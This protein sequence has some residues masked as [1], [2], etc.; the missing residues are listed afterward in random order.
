VDTLRSI[1]IATP[2]GNFHLII[3][4]HDIVRASGFGTLEAL[5]MRLPESIRTAPLDEGD[6]NHPYAQLVRAYYTGDRSALDAIP[7]EQPGS[8]FQQRVWAA[9]SDVPYGATIS[10]KELATAADNPAAIRAA[11]TICGLNRLILLVPCHRVL[12][13]DGSIGSYLYGP[14]I[15]AALLRHESG[16]SA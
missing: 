10:Y 7:R 8:D 13:S 12:K 16:M 4:A 11:G 15:K 6:P 1:T 9:I 3:D 5:T 14:E 2:D